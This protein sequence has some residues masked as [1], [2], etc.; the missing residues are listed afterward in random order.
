[1]IEVAMAFIF[2]DGSHC[3]HLRKLCFELQV[4]A[5]K[6]RGPRRVREVTGGR[7]SFQ[8]RK[9]HELRQSRIQGTRND[10]V[11][12]HDSIGGGLAEFAAIDIQ[13]SIGDSRL[14]LVCVGR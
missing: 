8:L 5:L 4:T 10:F 6:V 13:S 12:S 11:T 7:G 14:L 2:S 1:M 3:Q 9:C